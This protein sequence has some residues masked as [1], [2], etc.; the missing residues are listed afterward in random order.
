LLLNLDRFKAVNDALGHQLGDH[1]LVACARRM[2]SCLRFGDTVARLHGDS[3]CILLDDI[4]D[5]MEAAFVAQRVQ[6]QL[7]MP[8]HLDG[9]EV[10]TTGSIGI[11]EGSN[12]YD[13]PEEVVLDA[14][15]A[16]QRAKALGRKRYE[17]FDKAMRAAGPSV[18]PLESGLRRAAERQELMLYYQPIVSL[19]SGKVV[20]LEALLR[21]RNPERGLMLPDDFIP[22]AEETGLIVPMGHWALKTACSQLRDWRSQ[23]LPAVRVAVNVSARQLEQ[24]DFTT[25]IANILRETDLSPDRLELELTETLVVQKAEKVIQTL[26]DLKKLGIGLA[27][28]DFGT[29]YSSLGYLK[30]F[31]IDTL[32]I[33]RSFVRDITIDPKDD[34]IATSVIQLAHSLQMRVVAEGVETEEQLAFLRWHHCDEIQGH[35]VSP[36]IPPDQAAQ[37]LTPDKTFLR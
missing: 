35:L 34:A 19:E 16:M 13:R 3:Y 1:L 30:R 27:I 29:G 8:F 25:S 4:H 12:A 7:A 21:W 17:V 11:V 31:F 22:L 24:R 10:H 6:K 26:S 18:Q 5:V 9:H 33:D 36:A 14:T 23:G 28:D 20:C 37:L 2:E 15:T 32:K